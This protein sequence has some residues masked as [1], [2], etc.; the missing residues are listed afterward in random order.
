MII[1]SKVPAHFVIEIL[2]QIRNTNRYL[3]SRLDK[4]ATGQHDIIRRHE[5]YI[6]PLEEWISQ[7]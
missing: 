2:S 5:Q 3:S 6:Q 4:P 1:A 7:N